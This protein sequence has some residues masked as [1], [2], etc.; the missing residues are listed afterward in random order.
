[1][2]IL[3]SSN[4]ERFLY[5]ISGRDDGLIA[6]L[7]KKLNG[8]G[9]Y[10]VNSAMKKVISELFYGGYCDDEHTRKTIKKP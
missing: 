10:E 4:L 3:I 9:A 1:M 2:D 6:S 8:D 7:M 5:D